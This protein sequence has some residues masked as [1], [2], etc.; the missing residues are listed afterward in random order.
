MTAAKLAD[1][2]VVNAS[3]ASNAAIAGS[4]ISPDFGSQAISTTGGASIN[5][6]TVFNEDGADVDFRI[7]SDTL[8][9]A[10]FST[11]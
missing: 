10:F 9:H 4:K 8:T 2:A 6:A 7:E 1:N 3:V 5:G 11:S